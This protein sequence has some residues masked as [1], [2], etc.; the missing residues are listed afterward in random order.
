MH[1]I[2]NAGNISFLDTQIIHTFQIIGYAYTISWSLC[3]RLEILQ[4]FISRKW[5]KTIISYC[6]PSGNHIIG[7]LLHNIIY[8]LGQK[9]NQFYLM[10]KKIVAGILIRDD[11][12]EITGGQKM[13]FAPIVDPT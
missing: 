1:S 6:F 11:F 3:F 13:H 7:V 8:F 5:L 9:S 12:G 2:F 4:P 10:A